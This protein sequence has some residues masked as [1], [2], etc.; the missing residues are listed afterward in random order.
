[1]FTMICWRWYG[2]D[3]DDDQFDILMMRRTAVIMIRIIIII[4][5]TDDKCQWK[6][7][8]KYTFL[9]KHVRSVHFSFKGKCKK[10]VFYFEMMILAPLQRKSFLQSANIKRKK[11]VKKLSACNLIYFRHKSRI[12]HTIHLRRNIRNRL[13]Y[14]LSLLTQ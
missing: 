2:D 11:G 3:D 10:M 1:M 8:P 12:L 13:I 7:S 14:Y 4:I 9:W 5:M 6:K